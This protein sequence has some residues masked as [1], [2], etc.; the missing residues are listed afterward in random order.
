MLPEFWSQFG[1]RLPLVTRILVSGWLPV[2][3]GY[4][5]FGLSLVTG[6][7]LVTKFDYLER[8][9]SVKNF[10]TEAVGQ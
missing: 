7:K 5:N 8:L 2:T 4:Q 10:L 6:Y 9:P 1:P 3:N